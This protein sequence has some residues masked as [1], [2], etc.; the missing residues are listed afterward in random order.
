MADQ[1]TEKLITADT[2]DRLIAAHD[3][4][5]ALLGLYLARHPGADDESAAAVLCRTRAEIASAREKLGRVL[6]LAPRQEARFPADEVVQYTAKEIVES[7]EGNSRFSPLVDELARILGAAPSRAYLNVL[8]DMYDH[9]GMPP[10][11][12]MV[13]LNHCAAETK[14]R[15]GE[16]RRP[17]ARAISEEAYRWANREIL[18]LELAE[19]YIRELERRREDKT[20]VAA[21]L[22]IRGREPAQTEGKYIEAWLEMGFDDETLSAALD[23]TLTNTGSLK[24]QYMNGIL[25]N[26]HAKGLHSLDAIEE[27]EGK[28]RSAAKKSGRFS[29]E[30]DDN[31]GDKIKQY[32]GEKA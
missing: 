25:K 26:W 31:L 15:W 29:D 5:V 7:F 27:A 1:K 22:G 24:W 17:T 28:R 19:D 30:E 23:K 20:R 11:V 32:W 9:L 10:E 4:D 2:A 8:V 18:T 16:S 12:I 6:N 13:L 14:R 21:L 3:A